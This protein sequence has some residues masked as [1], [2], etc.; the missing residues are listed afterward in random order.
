MRIL[1]KISLLF[2]SALILL[3]ALS[4]PLQAGGQDVPLIPFKGYDLDGQAIDIERSIGNS[5]VV[6]VFWA[7]WCPSCRAEVPKLN[8]LIKRYAN[9]GMDFIGVNVG[10]NDSYKRAKAFVEKTGMNYPNLFDATGNIGEQYGLQGVPTVIVADKKGFVRYYGHSTPEISEE[11]FR[12][13]MAD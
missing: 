8:A 11:A 3:A 9:R 4:A 5:A 7:S 10:Y 1:Q 6:L 13:L 12:Q 2:V